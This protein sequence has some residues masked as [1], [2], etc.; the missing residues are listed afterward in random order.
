V[1]LGRRV[2]EAERT[3]ILRADGVEVQDRVR[4]AAPGAEACV[5]TAKERALSFASTGFYQ[6]QELDL[7]HPGRF[8]L[9]ITPDGEATC[10]RR[11][12]EDGVEVLEA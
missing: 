11:I 4:L 10:R 8:R 5:Q 7:P 12:A 3:I 6:P 2:G 1:R 9:D